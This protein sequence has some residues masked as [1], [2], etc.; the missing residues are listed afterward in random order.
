M[1]PWENI[2][3]HLREK[4]GLQN[5]NTWLK[6][7]RFSHEENGA[8]FVLVPNETF[9]NWFQHNC[10]ELVEQAVRTIAPGI[11]RIELVCQPEGKQ[12]GRPRQGE[13]DFDSP[14]A[15]LNP[16]YVF[17]TFVIGPSN[18]FAHA[19]ADA[20]ARNPSK[21]YNPLFLYGG[22]GMGKT[23][24][25][26]AIAHSLSQR[27]GLRLRYV[28]TNQFLHEVIN[29]IRY[30]R[31]ASFH[32]RYRNLDALLVDDI[33]FVSSKERTQEEF[34]HTFNSLYEA[35]KQIVFASD[36]PPNEIPH[37]EERLRSR[38]EWGLMADIQP[39]DLETR[40]AIL[41][42]KAEL[43]GSALPEEVALFIAS[44]VQSNIRELEGCLTRVL[45]YSSLTGAE[46]SAGMAQHILKNT[47]AAQERKVNIEAIQKVVAD[48]FKLR[49][50]DLRARNNSKRVVYPRQVAMYLCRELAGASLP[51]IGRAFGGKHHTT[52][53]HSTEKI[54]ELK[55]KDHELNRLINK[56]TDS[57][58]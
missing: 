9:R 34:F 4:L 51:E 56:L 25:L 54:R 31:M 33:H 49:I 32:D 55:S 45:A 19:A 21:A 1:N 23:H 5:F 36:R 52:V 14:H 12:V 22:V 29:S 53:L 35:Q 2:L 37:L 47:L 50:A 24:L 20:V 40:V 44:K 3:E 13:L 15:Q 58:H 17:E 38:F 39:P 10:A 16:R 8:L 48:E 46:I 30:D 57:L 11:E 26:Q 42:K 43:L 18:Q 41:I 6:P 27:R 28:T 7:V